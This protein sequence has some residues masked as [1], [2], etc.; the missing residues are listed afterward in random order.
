MNIETVADGDLLR[1]AKGQFAV[2]Q[3][4]IESAAQAM[5]GIQ[6]QWLAAVK[7]QIGNAGYEAL[8]NVYEHLKGSA[9]M[10]QDKIMNPL[11]SAGIKTDTTALDESERL[12]AAMGDDGVVNVGNA[13]GA[14]SDGQFTDTA[15]LEQDYGKINLNFD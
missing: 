9:H 4:D 2:I 7:G 6:Q 13:T 15:V 11:D 10:I 3:G 14:W 5:S 12:R 1:T 8:G